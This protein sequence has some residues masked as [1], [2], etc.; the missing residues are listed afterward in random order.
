MLRQY[1]RFLP[2]KDRLKLTEE[3]LSRH[4]KKKI[5]PRVIK[6]NQ[7]N[8][9]VSRY[10]IIYKID[11]DALEQK[12]Q[13]ESFSNQE[14]SLFEKKE[15]VKY[16]V[17]QKGIP[18]LNDI[19]TRL[20]TETNYQFSFF[21][22]DISLF[23]YILSRETP[24]VPDLN[25]F[26]VTK[27]EYNVY[28]RSAEEGSMIRLNHKNEHEKD[29]KPEMVVHYP[30]IDRDVVITEDSDLTLVSGFFSKID[31]F[32]S[33][34]F[35]KINRLSG[36][37]IQMKS[38]SE[39]ILKTNSYRRIRIEKMLAQNHISS[40][41]NQIMKRHKGTKYDQTDAVHHACRVSGCMLFDQI[42]PE[43]QVYS[44]YCYK[45][46]FGPNGE[47]VKLNDFS[48]A[49]KLCFE[50]GKLIVSLWYLLNH[51]KIWS[52]IF[53]EFV[54]FDIKK[55]TSRNYPHFI[56]FQR[57]VEKLNV[58]IAEKEKIDLSILCIENWSRD[59]LSV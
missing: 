18:I 4:K 55:T 45:H 23:I 26:S 41:I 5:Q 38:L 51:L 13:D 58:I 43:T 11:F 59:H 40:K 1:T 22:L 56:Y 24:L 25:F 3:I 42:T 46:V 34:F 10:S 35:M 37:S 14:V 52:G 50:H 20:F 12:F 33:T 21:E 29:R 2:L 28:L 17:R 19:L 16:T 32:I 47:K 36:E 9:L 53:T 39:I 57:I 30:S 31:E 27:T 44:L 15:V 54:L 8:F 48:Y 6:L 49:F 7:L